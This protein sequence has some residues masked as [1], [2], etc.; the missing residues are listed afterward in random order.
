MAD[1][2]PTNIGRA[3]LPV[4]VPHRAA[5]L[6]QCSGRYH[7]IKG[8]AG[9]GRNVCSATPGPQ[10]SRRRIWQR[11]IRRPADNSGIALPAAALRAEG[12]LAEIGRAVP[13]ANGS[14]KLPA[15]SATAGAAG[16]RAPGRRPSRAIWP[17]GGGDRRGEAGRSKHRPA[18]GEFRPSNDGGNGAEA[19]PAHEYL[20]PP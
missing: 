15:F 17:G 13:S 6:E 8:N 12:C 3:A 2:F 5:Y 14:R 19:R 9:L 1:R 4:R 10:G 20:K 16:R 11:A 7:E 18:A